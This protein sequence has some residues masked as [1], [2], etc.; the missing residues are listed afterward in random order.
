VRKT[1]KWI[2]NLLVIWKESIRSNSHSLVRR[3]RHC[4]AFAE[5]FASFWRKGGLLCRMCDWTGGKLYAGGVS[6]AIQ[7]TLP[8]ASADRTLCLPVEFMAERAK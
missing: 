2:K 7:F 1:S 3:A 6:H 4:R 8:L 5:A